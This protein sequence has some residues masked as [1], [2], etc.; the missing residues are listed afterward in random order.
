[1]WLLQAQLLCGLSQYK[2]SHYRLSYHKFSYYKLSYQACCH[3]WSMII[4]FQLLKAYVHDGKNF[5]ISIS[6]YMQLLLQQCPKV[7]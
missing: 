5:E 6:F 2:L 1:M 7:I 3:V 4:S